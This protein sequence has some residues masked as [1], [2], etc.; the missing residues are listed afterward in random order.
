MQNQMHM[1]ISE[2]IKE[3]TKVFVTT[4]EICSETIVSAFEHT[5]KQ[6]HSLVQIGSQSH[7][8]LPPKYNITACIIEEMNCFQ[9]LTCQIISC[10]LCERLFDRGAI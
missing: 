7:D 9:F 3:L 6:I 2:D 10:Q 5:V 8:Q 1:N 4:K